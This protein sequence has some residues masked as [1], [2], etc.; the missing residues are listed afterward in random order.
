MLLGTQNTHPPSR[1]ENKVAYSLNHV[2]SAAPSPPATPFLLK[3]AQLRL[4][5]CPIVAIYDL[6]SLISF[7]GQSE[8]NLIR[9]SVLSMCHLWIHTVTQSSVVAQYGIIIYSTYYYYFFI[10]LKKSR[11]LIKYLVKSPIEYDLA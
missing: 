3:V 10:F 5:H 1:C 11:L 8:C 4:R 6:Y 2:V 7:S 9:M